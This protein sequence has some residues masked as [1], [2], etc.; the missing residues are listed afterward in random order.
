MPKCQTRC[1]VTSTWLTAHAV[2]KYDPECSSKPDPYNPPGVQS[3]LTSDKLSVIAGTEVF[4]SLLAELL[5]ER[6]Q[7]RGACGAGAA[8]DERSAA[9]A[10]E[11]GDLLVEGALP[12][13]ECLGGGEDAGVPG[14]G[15]QVLQASPG[16]GSDEG[17]A[18][19]LGQVARMWLRLNAARG[20]AIYLHA[21][22]PKLVESAPDRWRAVNA[23]HLVALVCAGARFENGQL[24]KRPD[25][26][27]GHQQAA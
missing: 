4:A 24:V 17:A 6:S 12:E 2:L 8:V 7:D 3:Q 5:A 18:E 27:G 11:P 23:P 22:D 26:S 14:D 16:A 20:F 25:E 1:K 9:G 21:L 19:R 13:A 10:F 15:Q